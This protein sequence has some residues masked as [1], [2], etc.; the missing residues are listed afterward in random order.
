MKPSKRTLAATTARGNPTDATKSRFRGGYDLPTLVFAFDIFSARPIRSSND[1]QTT[2]T[3]RFRAA[4]E[5]EGSWLSGHWTAR[6]L[7][8]LQKP[9]RQL[10]NPTRFT[11]LNGLSRDQIPANTQSHSA[12]QDKIGGRLL[13]DPACGDSGEDP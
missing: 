11:T 5:Q 4:V 13:G 7:Y 10:V 6:F 12:G 3:V 2:F 8:E 1:L 9:T